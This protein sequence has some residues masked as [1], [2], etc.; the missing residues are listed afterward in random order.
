[1]KI[2]MIFCS[3]GRFCVLLTSTEKLRYAS[4]LGSRAVTVSSALYAF[5]ARSFRSAVSLPT[6]HGIKDPLFRLRRR[7]TKINKIIN[8]KKPTATNILHKSTPPRRWFLGF[9]KLS[10]KNAIIEVA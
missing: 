3:C 7:H 10:D 6:Y 5:F 9:I 4:W 8:N 1:M 2:E